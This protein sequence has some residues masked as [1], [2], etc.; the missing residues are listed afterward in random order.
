[1][2]KRIV[3]DKN[4]KA[5]VIDGTFKNTGVHYTAF[6]FNGDR[7]CISEYLHPSDTEGVFVKGC[8]DISESEMYHEMYKLIWE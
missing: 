6:K 7:W 1:M 3:R 8:E 2:L 5:V 4:G